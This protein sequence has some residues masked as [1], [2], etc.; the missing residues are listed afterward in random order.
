MLFPLLHRLFGWKRRESFPM[1]ARCLPF[2]LFLFF[3]FLRTHIA[4]RRCVSV[5]AFV[6]M[7]IVNHRLQLTMTMTTTTRAMFHFFFCFRFSEF[8]LCQTAFSRWARA[9]VCVCALC[10]VYFMPFYLH[11]HTIFAGKKQ[12][13]FYFS[14]VSNAFGLILSQFPFFFS[15]FALWLLYVLRPLQIHLQWWLSV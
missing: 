12:P 1:F 2:S 8:P 9:C 6:W 11:L 4:V 15:Y 5:W 7:G 3:R 13:R 10:V 14:S